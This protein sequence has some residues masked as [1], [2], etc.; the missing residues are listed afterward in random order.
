MTKK[1]RGDVKKKAAK[2][3]FNFNYSLKTK[4]GVKTTPP[5]VLESICML[6]GYKEKTDILY[7][8]LP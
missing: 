2:A 6:I 4:G 7:Q 1:C 3:T 8:K 5:L